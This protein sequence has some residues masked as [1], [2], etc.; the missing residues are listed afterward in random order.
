MNATG[1]TA[2]SVVGGAQLNAGAVTVAGGVSVNNGGTINKSGS[3]STNCTQNTKSSVSD[4]YTNVTMPMQSGCASDGQT[5]GGG[6]SSVMYPGTYCNVSFSYGSVT[7][8]PGVYFIN[9]GNFHLLAGMTYTDNGAGV[10]IILASGSTVT[11]DNGTTVT[12]SAP[13]TGATAGIVFYGSTDG[14]ES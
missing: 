11:I 1:K 5:Y 7:M 12:L 8:T 2:L 14:T 10:T 6:H 9:K 4:P 3:C 13:A